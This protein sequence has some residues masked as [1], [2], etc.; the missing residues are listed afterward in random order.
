MAQFREFVADANFGPSYTPGSLSGAENLPVAYMNWY[1]ALAFCDWL[2]KRWRSAGWLPDGYRVTLPS[3]VEWEKAARGGQ[4]V[5]APPQVAAAV[6]LA[7]GLA[8]LPAL[9]DN[10]LPQRQYPWGNEPAQEGLT[11]GEAIFRENN[12][13][14]GIGERCVVG[15]FPIGRSPVGCLDLSGQ[16]WEW[17]RS[18]Y[19]QPWPYQ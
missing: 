4:Q 5:P 14:A 6:D 7:A 1:D 12:Q 10:P 13:S 18:L 19:G 8:S 9:V 2:D 11:S 17:T 3:E 15:A 16:V